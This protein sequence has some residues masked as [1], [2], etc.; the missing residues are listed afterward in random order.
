MPID[1]QIRYATGAQYQWSNWLATGPQLVYA[2]YRKAKIGN[3]L[4]K[5]DYKGNDI[6]FFALNANWKF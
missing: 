3:D 5:G 4:L 1:R 6:F 2:D